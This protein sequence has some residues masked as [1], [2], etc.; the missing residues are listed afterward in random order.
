VQQRVVRGRDAGALEDLERAIVD[1]V[2][3]GLL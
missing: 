3:V 2:L 1:Q